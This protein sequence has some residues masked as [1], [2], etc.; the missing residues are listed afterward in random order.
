MKNR[1]EIEKIVFGG[2]GLGKIDGQVVFVDSVLP[3]EVV[4]VDLH[5]K[6]GY[7][8]G[9]L[10]SIVTPS[11]ER[12]NP[13]C[14]YFS[15]CGGCD[16]RHTHYEYEILMKE[17]MLNDVFLR[18]AKINILEKNFKILKSPDRNRYRIKSKFQYQSRK[19]GFYKK[20][21]NNIIE[22]KSCLNL[23]KHIDNIIPSIK[24]SNSFFL[25][26][27]IFENQYY[28]YEKYSNL[29]P[30]CYEFENYFF[31]H[32]PGNFI[33]ANRFL[34]KPFIQIVNN[35]CGINGN[36]VELFSGSGFFT[37]P[38]SFNF[39]RVESYEISKSSVECLNKSIKINGI[40]NII[41]KIS[42]CKKINF[43]NVDTILLDPPREG[44]EKDLIQNINN[45]KAKN[46]VYVSCNASTLA[47]DL[48]RLDNY[49]VSDIALIDMFP[50][51]AHFEVVV[52]LLNKNV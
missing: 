26:S 52:K 51:T 31:Y 41:P 1:V 44:C 9:Y 30:I 38:L 20:K 40:K 22:I 14:P 48:N 43:K 34:I 16:F 29:K 45:S 24:T 4:E 50:G 46:I 37:I 18:I 33:Q 28:R 11:K 3:H 2:K 32:L 39:D 21:S 17:Q 36:L 6:K 49:T 25:E 13:D 5:E 12:V 15:E 47:R 23:P 8:E 10:K 35:Y 42:N 19:F 7:F 27:H